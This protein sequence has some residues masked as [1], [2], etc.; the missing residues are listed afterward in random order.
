MNKENLLYLFKAFTLAEVLITVG[1]VGV[2][3]AVTIP[4]LISKSNDEQYKVA[5]KKAYS[6]LWQ[7]FNTAKAQKDFVSIDNT[8]ANVRTNFDA[9]KNNFKVIKSCEDSIT[10][11]CWVDTCNVTIL[12]CSPANASTSAGEGYSWG[13]VDN[14]GRFWNH[15]KTSGQAYFWLIVDTNGAKSPNRYGRDK[16][17]F[18]LNDVNG[19]GNAGVPYKIMLASDKTTPQINGC[20]MGNCYYKSYITNEQ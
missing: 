11:G 2:I 16:W 17:F 6:D 8:A 13:F 20:S 19:D 3:A 15:Y 12:D 18:Q 9:L 4:N 5:Y 14:S 7:A 10:E 1:I